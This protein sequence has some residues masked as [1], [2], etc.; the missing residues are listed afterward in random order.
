MNSKFAKLF[1]TTALFTMM[2]FG[3][4]AFG[5]QVEKRVTQDGDCTVTEL[6]TKKTPQ[7]IYAERW[8]KW[9][10]DNNATDAEVRAAQAEENRKWAEFKAKKPKKASAAI[11]KEVEKTKTV[12]ITKDCPE[13]VICEDPVE[14]PVLMSVPTPE[15]VKIFDAFCQECKEVVVKKDSLIVDKTPNW[16]FRAGVGQANQT[17]GQNPDNAAFGLGDKTADFVFVEAEKVLTHKDNF[18][19]F[20]WVGGAEIYKKKNIEGEK[21]FSLPYEDEEKLAMGTVENAGAGKS[22]LYTGPKV[23]KNIN[24]TKSGS[25]TVVPSLSVQAVQELNKTKYNLQYE[26][27]EHYGN[28]NNLPSYSKNSTYMRGVADVKVNV[29]LA[30]GKAGRLDVFAGA[31]YRH[32]FFENETNTHSMYTDETGMY[33]GTPSHT[34]GNNF[35]IT[36]GLAY[37][38][39][40]KKE[41]KVEVVDESAKL[42]AELER[43]EREENKREII[44]TKAEDGTIYRIQPNVE[45]KEV[46]QDSLLGDPQTSIMFKKNNTNVPRFSF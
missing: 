22:L 17:G 9:K 25:V 37:T 19:Q 12:E 30:E 38:I 27:G 21:Y 2:L 40:R 6:V 20:S 33:K 13:G 42:R 46:K 43:L 36:G 26:D 18:L 45:M 14:V 35:A 23:W 11:A 29:R 7:Q 15:P 5:Q 44:E 28:P 16:I 34:M 39:F 41:K 31:S 8:A 10:K 4:K 32:H 24:L 3:G 1:G